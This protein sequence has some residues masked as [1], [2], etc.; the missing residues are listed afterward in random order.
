L[1]S[2][3]SDHL[4]VVNVQNRERAGDCRP[5]IAYWQRIVLVVVVLAI[6]MAAA[7]AAVVV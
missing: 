6:K 3:I 4:V 7:V 2:S 1:A 5:A